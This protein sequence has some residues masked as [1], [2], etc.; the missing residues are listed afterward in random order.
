MFDK[1]MTDLEI[2]FRADGVRL[3]SSMPNAL[4]PSNKSGRY[5]GQI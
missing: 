1:S 4:S 2:F 3:V 5:F